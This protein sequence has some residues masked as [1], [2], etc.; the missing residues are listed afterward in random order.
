VVV[1]HALI[2]TNYYFTWCNVVTHVIFNTCSGSIIC[3][4]GKVY[5]EVFFKCHFE[6]HGENSMKIIKVFEITR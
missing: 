3:H 4:I 6:L 1:H 5:F 2:V